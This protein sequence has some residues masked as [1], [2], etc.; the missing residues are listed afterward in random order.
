MMFRESKFCP[1]C[2]TAAVAWMSGAKNLP[3]PRCDKKMLRGEIGGCILHECGK[4]FGLWIDTATFERICRDSEQQSAVLGKPQ[5]LTP[6][7]LDALT[8]ERC[9]V[10]CPHCRQLMNRVNFAKCSGVIVDV[11]LQHGTW[12]D[13]NELHR[14][15]EFI[16]SGGLEKARGNEKLELQTDRRQ[17]EESRRSVQYDRPVITMDHDHTH[18]WIELVLRAAGWIISEMLRR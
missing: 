2:G 12:F 10:K 9:Y 18:C 14:I 1:A 5:I 15:V 17:L 8:N 11:C 7:Q 3:C 6:P 4:C 13:M 16:R